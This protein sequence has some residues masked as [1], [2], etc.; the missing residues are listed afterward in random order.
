M[1]DIK[2]ASVDV[3]YRYTIVNIMQHTAVINTQ[4]LYSI[5]IDYTPTTTSLYIST[6]VMI[7]CK[8]IFGLI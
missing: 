8:V 1:I 7:Q 5:H 6:A 4:T 3:V 2:T